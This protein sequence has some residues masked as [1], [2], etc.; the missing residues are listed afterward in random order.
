MP[1]CGIAILLQ[2]SRE[3]NEYRLQYVVFLSG[4]EASLV[5]RCS[6]RDDLSLGLV[7]RTRAM[8]VRLISKSSYFELLF[9]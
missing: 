8:Q 9:V 1:L 7:Q 2:E 4:S 5:E 3:D 6:F